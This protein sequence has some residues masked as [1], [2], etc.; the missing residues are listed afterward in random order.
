MCTRRSDAPGRIVRR[1]DPRRGAPPSAGQRRLDST[2]A[3]VPRGRRAPRRQR[4]GR[5]R[6]GE[7]G[8]RRD[9]SRARRLGAARR[10]RGPRQRSRPGRDRHDVLRLAGDSR[11]LPRA[12]GRVRFARRTDGAGASTVPRRRRPGG[13]GRR[14]RRRRACRSRAARSRLSRRRVDV[15]TMATAEPGGGWPEARWF[16]DPAGYTWRS[17]AFSNALAVEAL[18]LT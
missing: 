17:E 16:T 1:A 3:L 11:V 15:A 7:R 10:A 18:V 8:L 5:D 9:S 14:G 2:V 4:C 12:R 6:H 13:P